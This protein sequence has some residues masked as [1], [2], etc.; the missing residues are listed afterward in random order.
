MR[1]M[2]IRWLC[3][4]VLLALPRFAS[5]AEITLS[6]GW[7][8]LEVQLCEEAGAAWS[9]ESGHSVEIVRGPQQSNQRY[10]EYLD[11]LAR[12]DGSIDILQI[13]VIWP[14]AL[15]EDLI[16]LSEHIPAEIQ[17]RHFEAIV[18]NNTVDERLVAM[19]WFTDA[20]MLFYRTDL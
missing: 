11:L 14:S 15:A 10:L 17:K 2:T 12:G 4:V 7:Q 20:G 5:A 8:E 16:D 18:A 1:L 9:A 19:P 3:V 6:C 13:D